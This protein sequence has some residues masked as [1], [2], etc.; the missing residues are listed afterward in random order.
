MSIESDLVEA[1]VAGSDKFPRMDRKTITRMQEDVVHATM[2]GIVPRAVRIDVP[3]LNPV[4]LR[5]TGNILAGLGQRL[6]ALTHEKH[7]DEEHQLSR[8]VYLVREAQS[9]ILYLRG[10]KTAKLKILHQ[11]NEQDTDGSD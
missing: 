1:L 4:L 6:M 7:L 2:R 10:G 8:A 5:E 3:L 9:R 11:Q